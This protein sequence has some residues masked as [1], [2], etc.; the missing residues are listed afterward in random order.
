MDPI[1][2]SLTYEDWCSFCGYQVSYFRAAEI[3]TECLSMAPSLEENRQ[4]FGS[5]SITSA[6]LH[7]A[8]SSCFLVAMLFLTGRV[9]YL[10][11]GQPC[12]CHLSQHLCPEGLQSVCSIQVASYIHRVRLRDPF[13]DKES[14]EVSVWP[15]HP[16]GTSHSVP[17]RKLTTQLKCQLRGNTLQWRNAIL[18]YIFSPVWLNQGQFCS[19]GTFGKSLKTF[20]VV[21]TRGVAAGISWVEARDTAYTLY[22]TRQP[23]QQRI[24][25]VKISVVASLR[26][27]GLNQ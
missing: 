18:Q 8:I 6:L 25:Q 5:K 22:C 27:L 24:I 3:N 14:M 26:N 9:R 19:Q 7:P 1:A 10:S 13:D 17:P 15:M 11:I 23:P 21:T 2:W 20:P 4:L 16:L 12:S